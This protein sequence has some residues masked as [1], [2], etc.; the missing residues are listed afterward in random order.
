MNSAKRGLKRPAVVSFTFYA[1]L[2]LF[3]ALVWEFTLFMNSRPYSLLPVADPA[4]VSKALDSYG[5]VGSL[6]TT[7]ATGLLAAMGWLFT[8]L[9][10]IPSGARDHW[11]AAAAALCASL[12]LYFGYVSTQNVQWA[13]EASVPS[14]EVCQLQWPRQLQFLG[15]LLSFL[16]MADFVRRDWIGLD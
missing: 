4:V 8:S 13:I 5:A 11:P 6:L 12:S 1:G 15:L 3:A 16:F 2:A 14:L 7:L 9:P 10:K